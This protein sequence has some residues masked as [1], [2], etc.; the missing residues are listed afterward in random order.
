MD[1]DMLTVYWQPGCSSCLNLKEHLTRHGVAFQ[2]VN[3]RDDSAGFEALAKLGVRQVPVLAKGDQWC[4]GQMI[5]QVN[6]LA[7]IAVQN[8]DKLTP[9]ELAERMAGYLPVLKA[10]VSQIPADRFDEQLP[11]RPRSYGNLACHCAEIID[12]FL[13]VLQDR[14]QLVFDDYEHPIP[15]ECDSP[16]KL[17]QY[18][19]QV[20]QRLSRWTQSEL[21]VQDFEM[22]PTVYYGAPTV[23]EYMERTAWH[24]G[25]HLRQLNLVL[26]NKLGLKPEPV[27]SDALFKGLP[28]PHLVWDD[29]LSF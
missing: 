19:S 14:H 2:S 20:A 5:A 29:Q 3:V 11:G 10:Y 28:M 18:V 9:A 27:L 4:D 6:A 15:P 25:Q 17:S 16:E 8:H 13:K 26:S 12:L 21:P 1:K 23:H 7:G 24:S 22:I